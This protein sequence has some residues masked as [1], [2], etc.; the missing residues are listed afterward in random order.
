M[1]IAIGWLP[2]EEWDC[3][4]VVSWAG[5]TGEGDALKPGMGMKD[6]PVHIKFLLTTGRV[7]Y[8]SLS[9]GHSL[10]ILV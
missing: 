1:L 7:T 9:L 10:C 8:H 2:G 4:R 3:P 6:G 5:S